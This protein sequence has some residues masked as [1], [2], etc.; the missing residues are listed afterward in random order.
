[1][2]ILPKLIY[3]Y[4]GIPWNLIKLYMLKERLRIIKTISNNFKQRFSLPDR[5]DIVKGSKNVILL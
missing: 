1:M 3:K 4:F 2:G 5:K